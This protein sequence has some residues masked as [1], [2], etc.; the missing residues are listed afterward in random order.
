MLGMRARHNT[1]RISGILAATILIASL[2][3]FS[4][5]QAY[6]PPPPAIAQFFLCGKMGWEEPPT[7]AIDTTNEPELKDFEN[8]V[9]ITSPAAEFKASIL[10]EDAISD[11][12]EDGSTGH[13]GDEGNAGSDFIGFGDVSTG[14]DPTPSQI[15]IVFVNTFTFRANCEV[16]ES[17]GFIKS[18][19]IFMANKNFEDTMNT[20]AFGGDDTIKNTAAHE[21]GHAIGLKHTGKPGT[22][23][24]SSFFW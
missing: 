10:I 14:T 23:M 18:A 6:A 7:V 4:A 11:F 24:N 22:L 8:G 20:P 16:D 12:W 2:L 19:T 17:S 1:I 5:Q 21:L 13:E 3:A 9:E 15:T